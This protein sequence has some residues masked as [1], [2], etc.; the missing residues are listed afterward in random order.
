MNSL[1]NHLK[2]KFLTTVYYIS[3]RVK[4]FNLEI[5]LSQN[6]INLPLTKQHTDLC[7][8]PGHRLRTD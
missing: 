3:R 2:S 6:K 5:A 4:N 7:F 8:L 1:T